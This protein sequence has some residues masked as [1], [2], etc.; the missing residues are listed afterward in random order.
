MYNETF[1]VIVDLDDEALQKVQQVLT[2]YGV[3]IFDLF[4]AD[5]N[6]YGGS[7]TGEVYLMTCR[8][9][10]DKINKMKNKCGFLQKQEENERVLFAA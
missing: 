3:L 8:G 2:K 7:K 4:V 9:N 1:S 5:I 10:T 6:D